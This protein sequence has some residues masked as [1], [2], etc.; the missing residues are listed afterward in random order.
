MGK[1]KYAVSCVFIATLWIIVGMKDPD[2]K[3][4]KFIDMTNKGRPKNPAW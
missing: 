2:N 1:P 4:Y 3:V